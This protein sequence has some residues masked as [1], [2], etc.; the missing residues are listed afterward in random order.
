MISNRWKG[1]MSTN[2]EFTDE[3]REF[4]AISIP[5][6]IYEYKSLELTTFGRF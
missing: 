6:D 3:L 5:V 1:S 4:P 2:T